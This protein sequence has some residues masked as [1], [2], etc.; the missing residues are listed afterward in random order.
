[1]LPGG[2]V[3]KEF[4]AAY[5][6]TI[7]SFVDGSQNSEIFI[8]FPSLIL[9]KDKNFK[10][11]RDIRNLIKRRL[12]MWQ[13]GL[14]EELIK[15]AEQC[16]RNLPRSS[17]KMTED[18]EAK[19]FSNLV[20][21]G[22]LRDA[23]RFI[24]DRQGGGVMDPDEVADGDPNGRTVFDILREKHPD[25]RVALEEDFL[26]CHVL[27][28]LVDIEVT[29]A[30]VE[31]AAKKISGSAGISGFDSFQLQNVLLKHGQHSKNLRVAFAKMTEKMANKVLKWE[32]IRALKA[33]RL[34]ALKKNTS[35]S[36]TMWYRRV[37]R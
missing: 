7:N 28:N 11:T 34:I 4:V 20:L 14:H 30:H 1:M 31:Q 2:A 23:V 5:E 36:Q 33:K 8:C 37:C 29:S 35:R 24:T 17:T 9:Q 22:R 3:A 21:Q 19:I 13:N 6:A 18:K 25:Q 26:E 16:D 15:E 27:P 12:K 32:E 10:R